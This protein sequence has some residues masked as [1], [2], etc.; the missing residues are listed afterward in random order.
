[1]WT[2]EKPNLS[3]AKPFGCMAQIHIHKVLRKK[4]DANAIW[5]MFI[6]MSANTKGW[7]FWLPDLNQ[8][9]TSRDCVFYED[10]TLG[11]WRKTPYPL[12]PT[13]AHPL[14]SGEWLEVPAPESFPAIPRAP[15]EP[16]L[17]EPD[18]PNQEEVQEEGE[19]A[20]E[21]PQADYRR[22]AEGT[23]C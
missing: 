1:M 5:G 23:C 22:G 17:V 7:L 16:I 8:I 3:M 14:H 4:W 21:P 12:V 15:V 9:K 20:Q 6:G 10:M 2:G 13:P 19:I 18:V 11:D